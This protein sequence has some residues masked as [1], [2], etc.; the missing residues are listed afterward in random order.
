MA[1]LTKKHGRNYIRDYRK[2]PLLDVAGLPQKDADGKIIY[3][4]T[5]IW[6]KSSKDDKFAKIELGKY[7][8]DKDRG[9]IG[10]GKKHTA[11]HDVKA[12]YLA[13]SKT[14][15]APTSVALDSQLFSNIEE[16]YPSISSIGDLNISFCEK[17]FEWL[18]N[19]KGNSEA[20]VKRKGTTLKNIGTKLVDWEIMQF[21]PL[22]KLKIPKVT[23]EKE[24]QFWRTPQEIKKVIDKSIGAWKTINMLGFCIGTRLAEALSLTRDSFDFNANVYKIQSCGTF[25]TKSRKFRV[26]KIPPVLKEYLVTLKKQLN[27][28]KNIKTDKIVVYSDGSTPTVQSASS[29]LRKFYRNAGF[30]RFHPHCLRHTFAAHYLFKYRDIYGLSQLLGHSNVMITQKYYGHLLG[31]YFDSS[32][33]KFNPFE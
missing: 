31:N 21:N 32:M 4:N 15:K 33:T 22:Q 1:Y 16:F 13:Y 28:N 9:R 20:T 5:N 10:I 12:K 14:N 26:G 29:Y 7:E 3:K 30:K 17:F 25:R 23:N 11:W 19:T 18:K 6:I 27:Q 2:E 8:E 24:I